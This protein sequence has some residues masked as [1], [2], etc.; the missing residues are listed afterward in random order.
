MTREA[1]TIT[2]EMILLVPHLLDVPCQNYNFLIFE[3]LNSQCNIPS[4][5][6]L[7]SFVILYHLCRYFIYLFFNILVAILSLSI[8]FLKSYHIKYS[9]TRRYTHSHAQIRAHTDP[10]T[11]IH[12]Y[13]HTY[14]YSFTSISQIRIKYSYMKEGCPH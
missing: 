2:V 6:S 10:Y 7:I 8:L 9:I 12:T 11:F 1:V 14:T 4:D 5:G 3:K 13:T